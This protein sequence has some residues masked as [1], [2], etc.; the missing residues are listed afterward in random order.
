MHGEL[1]NRDIE[2][3]TGNIKKV[4]VAHLARDSARPLFLGTASDQ[5][6]L[7]SATFCSRSKARYIVLDAVDGLDGTKS[8]E[9]LAAPN[10]FAQKPLVCFASSDRPSPYVI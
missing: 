10:F 6:P 5:F 1:I 9:A 8:R 3:R 4:L 7:L 2:I